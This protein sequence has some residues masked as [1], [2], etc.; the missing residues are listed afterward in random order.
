MNERD[1]LLRERK[2]KRKLIKNKYI[3]WKKASMKREIIK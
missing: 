1:K 3:E 2:R